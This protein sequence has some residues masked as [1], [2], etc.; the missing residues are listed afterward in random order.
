[1][2]EYFSIKDIDKTKTPSEITNNKFSSLCYQIDAINQGIDRINKFDGV[3]IADVVGLGKSIIASTIAHNLG[4]KTIIIAPPHL[5]DQWDDYRIDFDF[6]AKVYSTGKIKEALDKFK[7]TDEELLIILDE[8]HKHRNEDSESYKVLHQLCAGNKVV[9]LSATPFNND[10]KDIYALIK[11]FNTPGQ[12]TLK[13]VEN[14]SMEFHELFKEY[15]KIR[16]DLRRSKNGDNES[17]IKI[18]SDKIADRLRIMIEPLVIRRSRLDLNAIEEY[19]KDLE[20]QNFAFAAVRPPQLLEYELGDYTDLY[21]DTLDKIS[22]EDADFIGARYKPITYIRPGSDF[23]NKIKGEETAEEVKQSMGQAQ[24]NVA[25]FM[26][27]LLVKRFE[28]S[29]DAFIRS[30]DNMIASS[31]KMLSWIESREEVPVFKKGNIPEI[32]DLENMDEEEVDGLLSS[33][34]KKGM[35]L[36]PVSELDENFK[37]DLENDIKIFPDLIVLPFDFNIKNFI[38]RIRINQNIFRI[39]FFNRSTFINSYKIIFC[40]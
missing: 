9:A 1:M 3:I 13:T 17:E 30:L 5:C 6:N 12:S 16:R 35:I 40:C 24:T 15:K 21:I 39:N 28:S 29:V 22:S 4:L 10:P 18:R 20:K 25:K 36:I 32:E 26:R 27:R 31:E 7:D 38:S 37:P 8:A 33:L 14:L 2:D 34:G 23:F 11:L 19:R